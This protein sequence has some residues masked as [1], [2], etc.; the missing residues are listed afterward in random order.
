MIINEN[1][2]IQLKDIGKNNY[3]KNRGILE[4]LENIATHHSDMVGFGPNDIEKVGV[5][6]V[7]LDWKIKVIKRP[8]YGE[9][10]NVNTWARTINDE[11][12]KVYTYRDFEIYNKN[13]ELAVIGTSKWALI[14]IKNGKIAKIEENVLNKYGVEN[15]NV[16]NVGELD[17]LLIPKKFTHEI[18]YQISRRDID[19]NRHMHNLYYLDLA[20]EVLPQEVYEQRPFEEFRINYKKEVRYGDK[21]KCKY[22][23]ENNQ[24]IVVICN[25]EDESKVNAIIVLK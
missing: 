16:F 4:I 3:I 12:K 9:T 10:V 11:I 25:E 13:N 5:S 7:L 22:T 17:R 14:D 8:K 19:L 1:F 6:W 15:K 23:F 24:H 2:K 21:I 20:Y 18:K